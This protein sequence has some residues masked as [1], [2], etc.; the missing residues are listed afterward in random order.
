MHTITPDEK[1]LH[2]YF[3]PERDPILTIQPGDTVRYRTLDAWWHAYDPDTDAL[4]QS[5]L[6]EQDPLKGHA[7]CGPIYIEG[8]RQ[9]M[10]LGVEVGQII[11]APLGWN[12]GGGEARPLWQK[13]GVADEPLHK[14]SWRLDND[15]RTATSESG[16]TVGL[17][18]F[19]GVMGMPPAAP[20]NHTTRPPY[21]HGGNIDCKMLTS[22][23]TLYLPIPVE[24]ALFSVGD[25]HAVQGDGEVSIYAVECPM[26]Q[27]DLTFTLHDI[28]LSTPRAHTEAGW[29]TFGFH[30][31]LN[32]AMLIALNAMLDLMMSEY[33][34]SRKEALALASVAVDL[35]ITQ[36]VNTT[37]GVHAVL[38]HGALTR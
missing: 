33:T 23:S 25:G 2:G 31:D 30:E 6:R 3:S 34:I 36:I 27:A 17:A 35:R 8:A 22:G 13:L 5:P 32:K 29:V 4:V 18:P 1:T 7:L 21:V 28:A 11:T 10:V 38:P 19:M 14:L 12:L 37:Q 26:E 9:G 24:G 20:G 15:A 16:F